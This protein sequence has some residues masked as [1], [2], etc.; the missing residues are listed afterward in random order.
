M[1]SEGGRR[2]LG[3]A[4]DGIGRRPTARSRSLATRSPQGH[5][6]GRRRKAGAHLLHQIPYKKLRPVQV[7]P[8]PRQPDDG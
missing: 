1:G 5:G 3:D 6:F 4:L 8:P 2:K 7:E